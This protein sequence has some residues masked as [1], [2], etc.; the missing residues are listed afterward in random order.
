MKIT[1]TKKESVVDAMRDALVTAVALLLSMGMESSDAYQEITSA[2]NVADAQ[3]VTGAHV[4]RIPLSVDKLDA[5][6][7][8]AFAKENPDQYFLKGSG[9]LKLLNAIRALEQAAQ[10]SQAGEATPGDMKIYKEIADNYHSSA[11]QAKDAARWRWV[12]ACEYPED[13]LSIQWDGD[14]T[15]ADFVDAAIAK[16]TQ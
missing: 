15:L 4:I 5:N 13:G 8:E 10:P 14:G 16:A 9:V 3:E 12:S 6:A 7:L 1:D 2:L 11:Q